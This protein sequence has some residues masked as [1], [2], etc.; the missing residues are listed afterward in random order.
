MLGQEIASFYAS[1]GADT[2]GFKKGLDDTRVGMEGLKTATIA[3]GT[4]IGNLATDIIHKFG[5]MAGSVL[6]TGFQFNA[7][8]E[9][10]QI[11]FTTMLGSG[12]AAQGML[13]QLQAFAAKTPFEFPDLIRAS[14]RMMAMGFASQEVIPTLTAVGDA[15]AALGG[16]QFEIDRV[17]TALGQMNAKGKTSA[18]EMMQL[19]EAGIPA[20]Q[21]LAD[22]IGVTVPEAMKMVTKGAVDARTTIDAVTEGIETRFGGMMAKQSLTFNGLLSNLKDNFTQLSGQVMQPFFDMSKAGLAKI[23]EITSSPQFIQGIK[24]FAQ[25]G[26]QAAQQI[27]AFVKQGIEWG[28]KVLPPLWENLQQV[29]SAIRMLIQPI[30]NTISKFVS[31]KD[32]AIAVGA[33]VVAAIG[34]IVASFAPVIAGA[35]LLIAGIAALR[36]AWENDFAGIR[37]TTQS[38]FKKITDWFFDSSGIWKGTWEKTLEYLSWWADGGWKNYIFFPIRSRLIELGWEFNEWKMKAVAIFNDWKEKVA[39]TVASWVE[40]VKHKIGDWVNETRARFEWWR[41]KIIDVIDD[42]IDINMTKFTT[43]KNNMMALIKPVTDWFKNRWQDLIEWWDQHVQP[44]VERGKQIIQGL[45]DGVRDKWG[46]FSAWVRHKWEDLKNS[47][48]NAF[49]IHSPS[50]V[51]EDYGKN[52]VVGLTR[53]IDG[54]QNMVFDAMGGL[55]AGMTH[56]VEYGYAGGGSAATAEAALLSENNALLRQLIGVM[57]NKNMSVTVNAGGGGGYDYGALTGFTAAGRR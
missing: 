48:S 32:I 31:W 44:W 15:V 16:G 47:F 36:H 30:T 20:W 43:W 27:A 52:I 7:M 12:Q 1:I 9:Q 11:A 23:V 53:G 34:S 46:E 38:T 40:T 55:N 25:W 26:K 42:F 56:S 6:T 24:D 18:E 35:A 28:Q 33:V 37:T 54:A 57:Q 13:D 41:D 3:V 29:A 5:E 17:T 50:T 51:F 21:M 19:T 8:K 4:V 45:W 14:Q 49:G 10:S 2:S 22:K 39:E